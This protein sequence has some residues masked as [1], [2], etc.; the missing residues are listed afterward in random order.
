MTTGAIDDD[1]ER[2]IEHAREKCQRGEI[3]EEFLAMIERMKELGM[4]PAVCDGE[5]NPIYPGE[6][7]RAPRFSLRVGTLTCTK[8]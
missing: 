1:D 6:E 7:P 2:L 5:G 4:S 3:D 8:K